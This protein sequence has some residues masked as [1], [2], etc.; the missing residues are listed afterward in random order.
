[1]IYFIGS[2][3]NKHINIR[4]THTRLF[5]SYHIKYAWMFFFLVSKSANTH[6]TIIYILFSSFNRFRTQKQK[7]NKTT[8]GKLNDIDFII[9]YT[10]VY[11]YDWPLIRFRHT[12]IYDIEMAICSTNHYTCIILCSYWFIK[13]GKIFL[14][15]LIS[16]FWFHVNIIISSLAKIWFVFMLLA[17]C[18]NRRIS[19]NIES[20]NGWN[21]FIKSLYFSYLL[22]SLCSISKRQNKTKK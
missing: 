13:I 21:M 18:I 16:E 17:D 4:H 5:V 11:V 2:K 1:M 7:R 15:I 8:L 6:N 22:F 20:F 3:N 10:Y 19:N 9:L 12:S 14:C